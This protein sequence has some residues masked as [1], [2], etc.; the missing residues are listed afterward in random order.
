MKSNSNNDAF[1]TALPEDIPN[2]STTRYDEPFGWWGYH[3]APPNPRSL[4]WLM[5]AGALDARLAAFLSLAIE[6]RRTVI[7]VAEPNEAGKTTLLTALLDFRRADIKP[8]Y[9]RGW[10]ERFSFLDTVPPER[11]YLLCNEISAHLPTYLWGQGVRRVF[12]AGMGGYAFVTTMHANSAADAAE[13]LTRYPL[14]VPARHLQTI[15]L[16]VTLNAGQVNN[17]PVRRVTRVE[18]FSAESDPF[19]IEQLS[20]RPLL[21]SDLEHRTGRMISRIA[22]WAECDDSEAGRML[23]RREH[24]LQSWL[25]QDIVDINAVRQA[26]L[27]ARLTES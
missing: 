16:V 9:L 23:S 6:L 21:R 18:R 5:Q 2:D 20:A 25:N 10:Y 14:E 3:W 24:L 26:I 7:V 8:M 17:K 4:V 11:A 1:K 12:E 27:S 22:G 19:R 15:D 13:L